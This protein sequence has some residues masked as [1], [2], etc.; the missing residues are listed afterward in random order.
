M[1]SVII[2]GSAVNQAPYIVH[3]GA[4]RRIRFLKWKYDWKE[5]DHKQILP[6]HDLDLLVLTEAE[7][8]E[9]HTKD[10]IFADIEYEGKQ[11]GSLDINYAPLDQ[12]INNIEGN[13]GLAPTIL[14]DGVVL[15]DDNSFAQI[16]KEYS[17]QRDPQY[18]LRWFT[19]DE[20]DS[21]LLSRNCEKRDILHGVLVYNKKIPYLQLES[22]G[23]KRLS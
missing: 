13:T 22:Q 18:K 10:I 9:P 6:I 20:Y 8:K 23:K 7:Q 17:E 12:F 2:Y 15:C 11:T 1:H 16:A 3:E 4:E 14:R 19:K 21:S 5:Q